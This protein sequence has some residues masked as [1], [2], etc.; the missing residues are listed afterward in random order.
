MSWDKSPASQLFGIVEQR[1]GSGFLTT[2][3]SSAFTALLQLC[4]GGD[5]EYPTNYR[6]H[7]TLTSLSFE[8]WEIAN[9]EYPLPTPYLLTPY[10]KLLTNF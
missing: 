6:F 2:L 7:S 4:G 1:A 5:D 8:I 9:S 3:I 10:P